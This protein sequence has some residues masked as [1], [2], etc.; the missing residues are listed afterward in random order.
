MPRYRENVARVATIAGSLTRVIIRPLNRPPAIPT[1]RQ[2]K[3][4]GQ[5]PI[6]DR[7]AIPITAADIAIL[8]ATE[9]SMFPEMMIKAMHTA[10]TPFSVKW[11]VESRRLRRLRKY[12]DK[13]DIKMNTPTSRISKMNSQ[14]L[15][16]FL[17]I[18]PPVLPL[19]LAS[20]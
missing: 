13:L 16:S 12:G 17:I 1:R 15:S 7:N 10:I 3:A 9:R 2:S 11:T 4:D 14:C 18:A 6:P 20:A 5:M 8:E 19:S